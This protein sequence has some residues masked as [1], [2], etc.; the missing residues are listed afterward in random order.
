MAATHKTIIFTPRMWRTLK[1]V[2]QFAAKHGRGPSGHEIGQG[3]DMVDSNLATH[4][5]RLVDLGFVVR[6]AV[7][8]EKNRPMWRYT[9]SAKGTEWLRTASR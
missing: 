6:R 3:I 2:E 5:R 1:F 8:S 7:T 4:M 9:I